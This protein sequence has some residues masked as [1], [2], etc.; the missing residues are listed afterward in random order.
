V[1]PADYKLLLT[2]SQKFAVGMPLAMFV[3]FPLGFLFIINAP[4]FE[5]FAADNQPPFFPAFPLIFFL[6]VAAI[7]A[8]TVLSLP[9]QISVT[10]DRK[11]VFKSLMR[12]RSVKVSELISIESRSLSIQAGISGYLLKHRNGSI[13]FPGQ[14][15]GQYLLLYELKQ[16]NPALEIKGC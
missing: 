12:S 2:R 13:R 8:W 1:T 4:G 10:R 3:L 6:G 7:Y 5:G 16:A 11:L 9:Y 15:T 14:F